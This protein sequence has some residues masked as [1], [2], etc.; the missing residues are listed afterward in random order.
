[1]VIDLRGIKRY[2]TVHSKPQ[3]LMS[4]GNFA[5]LLL[6]DGAIGALI[7]PISGVVSVIG[8]DGSILIASFVFRAAGTVY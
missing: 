2:L 4:R 5:G 3:A 1:M 8:P 6:D 7:T